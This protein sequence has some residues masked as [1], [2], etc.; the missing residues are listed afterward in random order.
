MGEII[1]MARC[2]FCGKNN[3]QVKLMITH[4]SNNNI[5]DECVE[6]CANLIMERLQEKEDIMNKGDC[7]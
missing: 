4:G 1:H 5:C 6:Y 7:N 3:Y 2:S